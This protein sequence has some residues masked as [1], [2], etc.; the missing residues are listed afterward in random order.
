[1]TGSAA[2][3]IRARIPE[4]GRLAT[5][6]LVYT[7]LILTAMEFW[8]LPTRIEARLRGLPAGLRPPPSLDAGLLWAASCVLL[9]LLLPAVVLAGV[10]RIP[11]RD[12]G[13][14]ARGFLRHLGVYVGL[15]ALM[16]GALLVA[17][18]RPDFLGTYP[19]VAAARTEL[20]S[21]LIWEAAYLAQFF[22][23]ESF[24]RGFLLF[25][26]E[27]AI[28]RLAIPVMVVPY[29][30]IHFHKPPLEAFGAL[31]AGLVLGHLALRARSFYG[32]ALLHGLVALSMDALSAHRS[33][34]FG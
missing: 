19:F 2:E 31:A 16:A 33:G 13:F 26:L 29:T 9:Y 6:L 25:G 8:A 11:L 18:R 28:G 32:G 24:F 4:A 21:F 12:L 27:A 3:G 22:A 15:Y 1:V 20:P 5:G 7:A 10:F 14:R 30:M 34:L 17:S 23:L